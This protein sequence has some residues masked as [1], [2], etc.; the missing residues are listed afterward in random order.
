MENILEYFDTVHALALVLPL[1]AQRILNN[2]AN[3]LL[4]KS[5][6]NGLIHVQYQNILRCSP[7][8]RAV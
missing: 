6:C 7:F 1:D 8:P 5:C 3:I 4:N 2:L